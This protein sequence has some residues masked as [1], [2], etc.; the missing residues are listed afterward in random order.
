MRFV[1]PPT[2]DSLSRGRSGDD[3]DG[4][5]GEFFRSEMPQPWPDA[6]ETDEQPEVLSW[7]QTP[8]RSRSLFRSRLALAASVAF[9]LAIPWAISDS[10]RT[11]RPDVAD[12][13]LDE[14]GTASRDIKNS[15]MTLEVQRSGETG[16]RIEMVLPDEIKDMLP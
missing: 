11:L 7:S 8:R 9:L 3:L 16:V 1:A 4:L 5:L 14:T 2:T 13:I 10:F 15:K 12:I 6:P